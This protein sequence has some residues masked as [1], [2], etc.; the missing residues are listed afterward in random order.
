MDY[1]KNERD[2]HSAKRRRI[3]NACKNNEHASALIKH[4]SGTNRANEQVTA[5]QKNASVALSRPFRSPLKS[6]N[7]AVNL[8][9]DDHA[10]TPNT[11]QVRSYHDQA[12]VNT[13]AVAGQKP[14]DGVPSVEAL[15]HT[16]AQYNASLP[17]PI[18]LRDLQRQISA[19]RADV[20]SLTQATALLNST[21]RRATS[22]PDLTEKWRST[23]RTVA[24]E[25]FIVTRDQ[26]SKMGGIRVWRDREHQRAERLS[27]WNDASDEQR[28]SSSDTNISS[29][30]EEDEIS[31]E[32][33]ASTTHARGH[34]GSKVASKKEERAARRE[35]RLE[36]REAKLEAKAQRRAKKEELE[37]ELQAEGVLK[38]VTTSNAHASTQFGPLSA[39]SDEDEF[40]IPMMLRM[41][42]VDSSL[43]GY[44]V[45]HRRWIN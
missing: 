3:D 33:D 7:N 29:D 2:I 15:D 13:Q 40:T 11:K 39:I 4:S 30:D 22:L 26:I 38:D 41:L 5:R 18:N 10:L 1:Q 32:R 17:I 8:S 43:I 6:N 42:N 25:L 28:E 20:D 34:N 45:Q 21:N 12:S 9:L 44:D 37:A 14:S 19:V 31:D 24:E 27:K 35:M 16:A 36:I 23:A